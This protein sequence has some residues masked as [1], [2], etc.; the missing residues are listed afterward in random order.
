MRPSRDFKDLAAK[1]PRRRHQTGQA[2]GDLALPN[3]CDF[4][5][6]IISS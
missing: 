6:N 5:N 4:L 2:F 1:D 3:I